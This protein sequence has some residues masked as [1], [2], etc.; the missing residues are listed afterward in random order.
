MLLVLV[1]VAMEVV[2]GVPLVIAAVELVVAVC[3]VF[4]QPILQH[5]LNFSP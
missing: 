1:F 2:V 4:V 3:I 5:F